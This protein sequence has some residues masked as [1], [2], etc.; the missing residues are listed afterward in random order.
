MG[1]G[2]LPDYIEHVRVRRRLRRYVQARPR[3]WCSPYCHHSYTA[4]RWRSEHRETCRA[5][6]RY[7]REVTDGGRGYG[8]RD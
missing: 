6:A 1:T 2:W 7:V 4:E 8:A 3:F 5:Y